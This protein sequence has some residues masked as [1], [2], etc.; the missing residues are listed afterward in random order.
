MDVECE[1]GA[2]EG[3]RW[4]WGGGAADAIVVGFLC[5]A[6]DGVFAIVCA[7]SERCKY[8]RRLKNVSKESVH[9]SLIGS[10]RCR[11][12][13]AI[14]AISLSARPAL[15][16]GLLLDDHYNKNERRGAKKSTESHANTANRPHER[17]GLEGCDNFRQLFQGLA[18]WPMSLYMTAFA[19]GHLPARIL[20]QRHCR[21]DWVDA[22]LSGRWIFTQ[23]RV[24][25]RDV[26]CACDAVSSRSWCTLRA[27][28]PGCCSDRPLTCWR[29]GV[30]RP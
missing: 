19:A 1:E 27:V 13:R 10:V 11:E 17:D 4:R 25:N 9:N 5:E 7:A 12:G 29:G 21:K 22:D 28:S 18:A 14:H 26:V 6:Y 20:L 8:C 3:A 15:R 24:D 30:D 2:A 16:A 23:C